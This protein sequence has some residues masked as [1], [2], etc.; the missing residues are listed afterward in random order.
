MLRFF[1]LANDDPKAAERLD[2]PARAAARTGREALH[3]DRLADARLGD[4]QRIDVEV[5][6][7][8]GIRDGRGE[9]L[10]DILAHALGAELQDVQRFLDL[11]AAD[12]AGDEVELA[13]RATDRGADSERFLLTDLAGCDWLAH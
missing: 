11:A 12:Q 3:R 2:D 5:M 7:V 8:L 6:V 10:V 13:R 4:D 1:L 9:H